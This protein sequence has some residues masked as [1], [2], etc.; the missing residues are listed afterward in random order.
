MKT[1]RLEPS[2][3]T[4]DIRHA[5]LAAQTIPLQR[6]KHGFNMSM[7]HISDIAAQRMG[8]FVE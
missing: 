1:R 2:I 7:N 3:I 5:I 4:W 8:N 6:Y